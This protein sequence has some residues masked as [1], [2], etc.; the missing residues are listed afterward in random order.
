MSLKANKLTIQ[1]KDESFENSDPSSAFSSSRSYF[2]WIIRTTSG[3]PGG[4]VRRLQ[5]NPT[6]IDTLDKS[7][8][9]GS[10]HKA[11]P[12]SKRGKFHHYNISKSYDTNNS[13]PVNNSFD[14]SHLLYYIYDLPKEYW[15]RWPKNTTDCVDSGYL[16]HEHS[17]LHGYGQPLIPENGLFLTWHF[18]LFNSLHN[19]LIRSRRRTMDPEKASLFIIPYDLGLDGFINAD[20]CITRRSCSMNLVKNLEKM[21]SNSK[22]FNRYNGADHAVLWSLGHYHPWPRSCDTFMRKFCSKCTFTCYWMDPTIP[23]ANF[24]S[25]PFPSAYHWW[26]VYIGSTKTL[27]PAHTKIRRAM[28]S[29]CNVSKHCDWLQIGHSSIDNSIGNYLSIYKQSV[30]CLCPPGDDP[31]R[32][33][34]FDIILSGCIPVI[35]EVATL[36]NQYPWHIGEKIAQDIAVNIPG[37]Q[38]RAGKLKFMDYLLSISAETIRLKQIAIS[39]IAPRLQYSM[40]PLHLLNNLS[41]NTPWDPP[42]ADGVDVTVDGLFRRVSHAIK[43]EPTGIPERVLKTSEWGKSFS[44][45]IKYK[46]TITSARKFRTCID[47][48]AIF[49]LKLEFENGTTVIC[50]SSICQYS[51]EYGDVKKKLSNR[52]VGANSQEFSLLTFL[53]GTANLEPPDSR[54]RGPVRWVVGFDLLVQYD[55]GYWDIAD[56]DPRTIGFKTD[57]EGYLPR[58]ICL[59]FSV[60]CNLIV[61]WTSVP[62]L[63]KRAEGKKDETSECEEL[64][65]DPFDK[66]SYLSSERGYFI[67]DFLA[68]PLQSVSFLSILLHNLNFQGRNNV[69]LK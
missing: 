22:Y 46:Q 57:I 10:K 58:R 43:G 69:N 27:N 19:R 34:V 15:W 41:D 36:F 67:F 21:L 49:E 11:H 17:E 40:P 54:D 62:K 7:N 38:V 12:H 55:A 50:G 3:F 24:I 9:L 45:A 4:I 33:A 25:V 1:K 37:G 6:P 39:K 59:L 65:Y 63:R 47:F 61:L 8:N 18:S 60:K 31:A 35:F 5:I 23:N 68:N 14:V 53:K 32:K 52:Q 44:K 2:L 16:S 30:F 29:Q 26:E 66:S 56:F 64:W 42:F 48:A 51:R 28:T 13:I 20:T